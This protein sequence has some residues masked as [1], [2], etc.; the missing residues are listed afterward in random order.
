VFPCF[1]GDDWWPMNAAIGLFS[2]GVEQVGHA[3][4]T[5]QPSPRPRTYSSLTQAIAKERGF[6][7]G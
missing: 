5:V 6:T 1:G 3:V 2:A 7:I 4:T